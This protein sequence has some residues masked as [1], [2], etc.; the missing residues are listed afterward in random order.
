MPRSTFEKFLPASG[1]LAGVLFGISGFLQQVPQ[2]NSHADALALLRDHQVVNTVSAVAGALFLVVMCF[3]TAGIRQALRSGEPGESSYSSVAYAGGVMLGTG[4][5]ALSVV[6]SRRLIAAICWAVARCSGTAAEPNAALA[7]FATRIA[8]YFISFCGSNASTTS[9]SRLGSEPESA[10][11]ARTTRSRSAGANAASSFCPRLWLNA[12][13][14]SG[15]SIDDASRRCERLR[16]N[17]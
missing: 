4:W 6:T 2:E 13:A 16:S 12:A 8:S 9:H 14:A 10:S 5:V 7:M 17:S 1:V 11:Q 3:F 15:N